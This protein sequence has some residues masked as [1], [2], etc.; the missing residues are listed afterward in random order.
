KNKLSGQEIY[1]KDI[2][3]LYKVRLGSFS[4]KED[5]I[6]FLSNAKNAGFP[7]S[8]VVELTYVKP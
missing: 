8:F 6:G 4:S 2:D 5:A 3:G 7:D 1:Y